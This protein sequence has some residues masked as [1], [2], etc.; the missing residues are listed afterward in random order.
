MTGNETDTNQL[1]CRI[2]G[3]YWR[4]LTEPNPW[5]LVLLV[6]A[7]IALEVV[8]HYYLQIPVV[9]THFYYLIIVITGLWYGRRAIWLALFFGALHVIVTDLLTGLISAEALLRA[10]MFCLVAFVVG[11]I[12]EQVQCYHALLDRQ[13]R[14]L[15]AL[16]TRLAAGNERLSESHKALEVANRKLNLLN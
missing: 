16:N 1:P 5:A 8:V 14:D 11:T 6:L 9:Y 15:Q 10:L 12:A 2:E 13:N 3:S 7:G 4:V